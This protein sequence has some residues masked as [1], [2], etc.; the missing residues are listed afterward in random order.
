MN[1]LAELVAELQRSGVPP[2]QIP[3][4]IQQLGQ[5][6]ERR[7]QRAMQSGWT[8]DALT[9]DL[10]FSPGF[11]GTASLL[12]GQG[13]VQRE[14]DL[15]SEAA[16]AQQN[17][18]TAGRSM[19]D[20]QRSRANDLI[21][22]QRDPFNIVAYLAGIAGLPE[23]TG[24]PVQQLL[25]QGFRIKPELPSPYQQPEYRRLESS[26]MDFGRPRT[27]LENF[28]ESKQ[29]SKDIA[30]E[31]FGRAAINRLEAARSGTANDAEFMEGMRRLAAAGGNKPPSL[32]TGGGVTVTEPT[33]GIGAYSG[34]PQFTLAENGPE[35]MNVTPQAG[36]SQQLDPVQQ[37]AML[38]AVLPS[39]AAL[40]AYEV[41]KRTPLGQVQGFAAGT[42]TLDQ[43]GRVTSPNP[44]GESGR[45]TGS[46][47][48]G[49]SSTGR[50]ADPNRPSTARAIDFAHRLR[51]GQKV[52]ALGG[53]GIN[54]R[55][56]SLPQL[57]PRGYLGGVNA[58]TPGGTSGKTMSPVQAAAVSL[59]K[60]LQTN[61][62]A[63]PDMVQAL[64]A[65]QAPLPGSIT[66]RFRSNVSPSLMQALLAVIQG[67]GIPVDDFQN[68][69]S[70]F[71]VPGL[72]IGSVRYG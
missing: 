26:L 14:Q 24:N 22:L 60:A 29:A 72:R 67:Q 47:G 48:I 64:L 18:A 9:N 52:G 12:T 44:Y 58:T 68:A 21:D 8:N 57:Q 40:E 62:F 43:Y 3:G 37:M 7:R 49:R 63:T 13:E 45:A 65:G 51:S 54:R 71:D 25:G 38:Q 66:Q 4:I 33:V 27:P 1:V 39:R 50:P 5:E 46:V 17:R 34:R 28:Q 32:A 56:G 59:G 23:G 42:N 10:L 53:G 70:Q 20:Y 61:P 16:A 11:E 35:Q 31:Q 30:T 55:H 36:V 2:E 15:L 41:P 19:L 6:R 69:A